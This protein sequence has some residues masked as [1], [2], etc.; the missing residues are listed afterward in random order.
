[1]TTATD[2]AQQAIDNINALKAL[3]EKNVE[4]PADVQ[5]Q[6]DAYARQVDKLTRQSGS[7][8]ETLEGYSVNILI[9]AEKI[10]LAL[11]IMNKI[12]NGLTDK[13]IPQMPVT[14]RCQLTETLGYVTNRQ[15][16]RLAFRKEGDSEPRSYEEYRMG[17]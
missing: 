12:E 15:K 10:G 4:T 3:A 17:I 9:D 13:T 1:M 2:L 7:E 8:Q 6:L 14:L 11:E 16:E 5:A